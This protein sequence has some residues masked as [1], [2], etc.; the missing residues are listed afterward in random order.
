MVGGLASRINAPRAQSSAGEVPEKWNEYFDDLEVMVFSGPGPRTADDAELYRV[1][2]ICIEQSH[3]R[4][5][6]DASLVDRVK[7]TLSGSPLMPWGTRLD[8]QGPLLPVGTR[9]YDEHKINECLCLLRGPRSLD[10]GD[11]WIG[12]VRHD[13]TPYMTGKLSWLVRHLAGRGKKRRLLVAKDVGSEDPWDNEKVDK[14][15]ELIY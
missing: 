10:M 5:E 12:I 1:A 6:N 13:E 11:F 4:L 15:N 14:F 9:Q 3:A 2:N 8:V 7:E